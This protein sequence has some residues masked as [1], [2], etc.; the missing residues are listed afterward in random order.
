MPRL[1]SC[2]FCHILQ[3]IPDVAPKTP[4]IPAI[5]EWRDGER[6][7][8]RDE[9]GQP[10]MVPAYDPILEDFISKHEHGMDDNQVIGGLI[11]VFKVDQRTWDSMDIVTQIKKELE[12]QH[13]QHYAEVDEYK[14]SATKCY[15]AHGN[16]DISTGCRDYM[17]DSKLIGKG[18]YDD[19]EGHTITVPPKF[20]QYLCYLCPYQQAERHYE[21]PFIEA[22]VSRAGLPVEYKT[23]DSG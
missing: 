16:P 3:R 8:Y 6:Y 2:N 9:D 11:Q 15:N 19:G 17:D 14:E 22:H 20:R 21:S 18:S 4:L 7:I 1:A 10:V 13:R 23:A 12:Q 5:L